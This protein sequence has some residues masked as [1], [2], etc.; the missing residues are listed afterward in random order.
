MPVGTPKIQNDALNALL[1]TGT[2]ISWDDGGTNFA[3]ALLDENYS[4]DAADTD[5]GDVSADEV[6]TGSF[7]D[8]AQIACTG[9]SVVYTGGAAQLH[10]DR[11]DFGEDVTIDAKWLVCVKGSAGSLAAGAKII[12]VVDLDN[13]SGSAVYSISNGDFAVRSHANGWIDIKQL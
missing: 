1:A 7:P 12:F 9:R 10:S 13:T 8:Y 2:G 6:D 11:A 4:R 5:W 3:F